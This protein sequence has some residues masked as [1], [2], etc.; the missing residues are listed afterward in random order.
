VTL[1]ALKIRTVSSRA[2]KQTTKQSQPGGMPND[3]FPLLLQNVVLV[4]ED[5]RQRV[6]KDRQGFV[7]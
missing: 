7:E 5:P 3:D 6:S 1:R 4:F 2:E